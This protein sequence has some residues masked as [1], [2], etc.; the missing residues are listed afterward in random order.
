MAKSK[1]ELETVLKENEVLKERVDSMED[2]QAAKFE[3]RSMKGELALLREA[4]E[5]K[6]GELERERER[7]EREQRAGDQKVI[8]LRG[9]LRKMEQELLLE[10]QKAG[11]DLEEMTSKYD[12]VN[13]QL[14]RLQAF[15][16]DHLA[17]L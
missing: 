14:K 5:S 10:K 17:K 16:K 11:G 3:N 13:G 9:E 15:I 7:W 2:Y 4:L 6:S 12:A 8:N 1:K